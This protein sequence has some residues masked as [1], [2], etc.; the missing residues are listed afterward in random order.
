MDILDIDKVYYL[1]LFVTDIDGSP[2]SGLVASYT[3]YKSTDDSTVIAGPLVDIGNGS[4]KANYTF[5]D[6]GQYYIIYNTP[7]GYTDEI[8]TVIIGV[9]NAK[10]DE[11][12]RAIGLTGEN[13]RIL[14][15]IYDVNRNLTYSIVKLYA[16]AGDFVNDINVMATY[17]MTA[18][19]N[20]NNEMQ[21]FGVKRLS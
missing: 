5:S 17:E 19:Y 13:K 1:N 4:Y 9:E 3:I 8:G 21:D 2:K 16:N 20:A 10:A 6:L 11:L 15:T 7:T 18:S 12:T 14:N